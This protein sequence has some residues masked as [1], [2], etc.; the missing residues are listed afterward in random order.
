MPSDRK[1]NQADGESFDWGG[2]DVPDSDFGDT[3]IT[4]WAIDRLRRGLGNEKPFFLGVGYYRPHIPLFTAKIFRAL[5]AYSRQTAADPQ[6]RLKRH[7]SRRAQVG[8]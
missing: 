2:F 8:D 4:T 5:Q 1:P 7:W 6:G 3:Q